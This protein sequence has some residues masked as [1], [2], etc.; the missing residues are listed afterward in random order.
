MGVGVAALR[1][2]SAIAECVELFDIAESQPGLFLHPGSQANLESPMG[3]SFEW[4]KRQTRQFFGVATGR[5]QDQRFVAVDGDDGGRQP[6]LD[7]R[8]IFVRHLFKIDSEG[9]AFDSHVAGADL[10]ECMKHS[11]L[12]S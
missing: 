8:E 2:A 9:P 11:P 6:D 5:G 10:V 3:N 4:S 1:M 12:P 7:R